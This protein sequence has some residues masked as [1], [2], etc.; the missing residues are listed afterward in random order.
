MDFRVKKDDP[1]K[2][3]CLQR[4]DAKGQGPITSTLHSS[5][6]MGDGRMGFWMNPVIEQSLCFD[7]PSAESI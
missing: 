4:R 6:R 2:A 1:D 3:H 5:L 7:L